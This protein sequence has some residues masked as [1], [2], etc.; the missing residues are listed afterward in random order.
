MFLKRPFWQGFE[1]VGAV[2]DTPRDNAP[3]RGKG[4]RRGEE[5]GKKN[6][7]TAKP[8]TCVRLCLRY[9]VCAYDVNTRL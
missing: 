8:L 4:R 6:V 5:E 3:T 2:L 9:D 7:A 1:A